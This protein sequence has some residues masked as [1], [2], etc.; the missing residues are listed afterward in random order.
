M[1]IRFGTHAATNQS[2][3]KHEPKHQKTETSKADPEIMKLIRDTAKYESWLKEQ[4]TLT[5]INT[6]ANIGKRWLG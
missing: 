6:N 5:A 1:E 4:A 2:S 3:Q